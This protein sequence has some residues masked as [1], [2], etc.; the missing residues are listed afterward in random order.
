M[1]TMEPDTHMAKQYPTRLVVGRPDKACTAGLIVDD[2]VRLAAMMFREPGVED[3]H[4]GDRRT[5]R[6]APG[7]MQRQ[8]DLLVARQAQKPLEGGARREPYPLGRDNTPKYLC[9]PP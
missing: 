1:A 4:P 5:S 7:V 2:D 8:G 6:C 9:S 3:L